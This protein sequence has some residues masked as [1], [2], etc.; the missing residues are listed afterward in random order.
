MPCLSHF[1]DDDHHCNDYEWHNYG[2]KFD[3]EDDYD[4]NDD[5]GEK[6]PSIR[7]IIDPGATIG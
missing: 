7:G 2:V 3:V 1:H 5:D 4:Y 6:L